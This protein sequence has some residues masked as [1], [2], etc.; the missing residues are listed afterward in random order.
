MRYIAI[1]AIALLPA[2]E[3]ALTPFD[4]DLEGCAY[5]VDSNSGFE[6]YIDTATG[7]PC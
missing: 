7:K 1:L 2:C 3:A 5:R 4:R 6:G